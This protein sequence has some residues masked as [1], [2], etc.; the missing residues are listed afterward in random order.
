MDFSND[1]QTLAMECGIK[2]LEHLGRPAAMQMIQAGAV[3]ALMRTLEHGT[4]AQAGKAKQLLVRWPDGE[5][6]T[7]T[8]GL[9]GPVVTVS[10]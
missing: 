4:V 8:D 7:K 5:E 1:H 10:R 9:E 2:V 3:Q 6:T